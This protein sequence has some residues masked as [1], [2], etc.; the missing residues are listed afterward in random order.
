M[1]QPD[2]SVEP[3][4]SRRKETYERLATVVDQ[5]PKGYAE[6]LSLVLNGLTRMD[7]DTRAG[8]IQ[9][10]RDAGWYRP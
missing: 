10:M 2:Q 4:G 8:A 6:L 9:W 1:P 7:E 3:S 5:L